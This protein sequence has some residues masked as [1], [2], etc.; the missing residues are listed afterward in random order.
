MKKS[1][2]LVA[3]LALL[4]SCRKKDDPQPGTPSNGNNKGTMRISIDHVV[5]SDPLVLNSGVY[6]NANGDTFTVTTFKYFLSNFSVR[7][8]DGTVTELPDTYF[9]VDHRASQSCTF[10]LPAVKTGAY[11]QVSFLIGIDSTRNVSGAQTGAL[12]PAGAA[13]GMFWSWS[14]GY[15]MAKVEGTSPQATTGSGNIAFHMGGFTGLFKVMRKVT[16]D[17]PTNANVQSSKTP[18]VHLKGDLGKWFSGRTTISFAQVSTIMSAGEPASQVADN[19][20]KMFTVEH[21][22]N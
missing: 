15:I 4:F 5:G 20:S 21:V 3:A 8:A 17:L 9:L 11:N 16:L 13:A 14:S 22:D 19:Y 18:E 10:E 12:D 6:R 2:F 1:L 7:A